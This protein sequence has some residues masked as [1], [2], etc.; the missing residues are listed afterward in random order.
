MSKS[1][2][3]PF[4]PP[5]HEE[6]EKLSQ[7]LRL[8]LASA[9]GRDPETVMLMISYGPDSRLEDHWWCK[10]RLDGKIPEGEDL[11]AVRGFVESLTLPGPDPEKRES[12][13]WVFDI[14]TWPCCR[15]KNLEQ[16]NALGLG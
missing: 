5:D 16:L 8:K 1:K 3:K 4:V 11:T 14:C 9:L 6:L 2:P 7:K 15:P 10:V 13:L 12:V